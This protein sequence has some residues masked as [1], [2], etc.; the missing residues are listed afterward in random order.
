L[1]K[2]ANDNRQNHD[3]SKGGDR[4]KNAHWTGKPSEELRTED[5]CTHP[6][7][8]EPRRKADKKQ[9]HPTKKRPWYYGKVG[10]QKSTSQ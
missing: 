5:C 7:K 10:D 8:G 4:Q 2:L 9:R 1:D 6:L 3:C